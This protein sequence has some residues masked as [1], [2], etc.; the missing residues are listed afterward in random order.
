[1][2]RRVTVWRGTRSDGWGRQL[3]AYADEG[4]AAGA[5]CTRV[6]MTGGALALLGPFPGAACGSAVGGGGA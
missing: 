4:G 5:V 6:C 2:C 1:M 3:L